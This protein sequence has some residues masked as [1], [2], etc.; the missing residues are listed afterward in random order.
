MLDLIFLLGD[1]RK[2]Q[3]LIDDPVV[4][5]EFIVGEAIPFIDPKLKK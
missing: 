3:T 4:N 1:P 2:S 5:G